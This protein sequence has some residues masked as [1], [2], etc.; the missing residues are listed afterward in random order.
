MPLGIN[1]VGTGTTSKAYPFVRS[2]I[3]TG[4]LPSNA[5]L[6]A[7]LNS[8]KTLRKSYSLKTG[9]WTASRMLKGDEF[10]PV[11]SRMLNV[12]AATTD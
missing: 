1:K 10:L 12:P 9:T 6:R 3:S 4:I 8:S 5:F 7:V 11:N 2:K